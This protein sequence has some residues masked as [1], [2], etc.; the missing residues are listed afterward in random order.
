MTSGWLKGQDIAYPMMKDNLTSLRFQRLTLNPLRLTKYAPPDQ[1]QT[2]ISPC[3]HAPQ[4]EPSFSN[5]PH[6]MPFVDKL[7]PPPGTDYWRSQN[8]VVMDNLE[9]PK[10]SG[11]VYETLTWRVNAYIYVV[12]AKPGDS[13]QQDGGVIYVVL[14]HTGSAAA[15]DGSLEYRYD[16]A[17][18][19]PPSGSAAVKQFPPSNSGTKNGDIMSYA[20][21]FAKDMQMFKN[22]GNE[23]ITFPAKYEDSIAFFKG[24]QS[25]LV[26]G[27]SAIQWAVTFVDDLALEESSSFPFSALSLL[28]FPSTGKMTLDFTAS[29]FSSDGV[30]LASETESVELDCTFSP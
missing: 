29:V 3:F 30:K 17:M 14:V 5:Q 24:R 2:S 27:P 21:S 11:T 20:L 10:A 15:K 18:K 22:G 4:S 25:G 6:P 26:N 16:V 13:F 1:R 7:V 23:G 19:S 12:N 28:S 9:L 8:L